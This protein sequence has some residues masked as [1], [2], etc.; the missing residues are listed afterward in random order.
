MTFTVDDL[1]ALGRVTSVAESPDGSWLAVEVQ[2]VSAAGGR[3]RSAVWRLDPDSGAATPLLDDACTYRAPQFRSDGALGVLSNRPTEGDPD[4]EP[5][6]DARTQVWVLAPGATAPQP[7]TDEP[8][9]VNSFA[10]P[11][12]GDDDVLVLL[13]NVLPDIPHDEQRATAKDRKKHGPSALHYTRGPV[14]HWDHWL[15]EAAPHLIAWGPGD[16]RTD[17]TPTADRE[18]RNSTWELSPDGRTVA[19]S[20]GRPGPLRL[21]EHDIVTIDVQTGEHRI[22]F[23]APGAAAGEARWSA[24]GARL[25]FTRIIWDERKPIRNRLFTVERDG[26]DL[27]ELAADWIGWGGPVGW[28]P[29]GDE[30]IVTASIGGRTGVYAIDRATDAVR[31]LNPPRSG[32]HSAVVCGPHRI[33]G[34]HSSM[35]EAPEVFVTGYT[36][37]PTTRV[38]ALSGSS[39]EGIAALADIQEHSVP[40]AHGDPVQYWLLV[41]PGPGPHPV[42]H[43]IH[44]GPVSAWDD[45]WHWRWNPSVLLARGYAI[46]MPNPRG[47]LGFGDEFVHAV[48]GNRWGAECFDDVMA[49]VEAVSTDPRIDE[50]R[51]AAMGGSFGGFMTNWMGV[52][53]ARFKCLVTHASVFDMTRFQ[54]VTD[55]PPF[56]RLQLGADPVSAPGEFTRYSPHTRMHRWSAPT[57]I[58]HGERDFRVPVGE[59]LALFEALQGLG[60]HSELMVFP[61]EN[62]WILKPRNVVAWYERVLTFLDQHLSA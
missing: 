19:I 39:R 60:I 24:D 49:V 6:S 31:L 11:R 51:M 26:T 2:R 57:L 23:T 52:N 10:F 20:R 55:T 16:A 36:Q 8:L 37:G 3:Y 32:S 45:A 18:H 9:G 56:W 28:S 43:W 22:V 50:T 29:S 62:H 7:R 15:A 27:Q 38:S 53:S 35:E 48:W 5:A 1:V 61:D 58:T 34:V 12:Q 44:G 42:V 40:G 46:S 14:R 54:G 13:A 25:L 33:V 59:G 30:A 17:L 47:S 4:E 41:P 21:D